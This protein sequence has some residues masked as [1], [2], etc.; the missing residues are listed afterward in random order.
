[1][2]RRTVTF[3]S[4]AGLLTTFGA[5]ACSSAPEEAILQQFF[6]ASRLNDGTSLAGF[7][8]ARFAPQTSG[9]ITGFDIAGISEEQRAP[10]GVSAVAREHEAARDEDL[11]FTKR[12]DAYYVANTE[13]ITRVLKAEGARAKVTGKDAEVQAAWSKLRDESAQFSKKVSQAL[14]KLKAESAVV[15]LS[16]DGPNRPADITKQ[17]GEMVS[18]DVTIT[19]SVRMPDGTTADRTL[20]VTMRRAVLKG[21][22]ELA[23]KWIITAIK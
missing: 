22:P 9:T 1:M 12:K 23:G 11:E 13:A 7:A 6:R 21:E 17:D 8:V 5:A 14:Q 18:K 15:E 4:L 19:A 2:R 16:L 20:V 3:L 10:L